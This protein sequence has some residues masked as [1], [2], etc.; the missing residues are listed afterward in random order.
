MF[1]AGDQPVE[2]SDA[3]AEERA[4]GLDEAPTG[5]LAA[6]ARVAADADAQTERETDK[7]T[8]RQV[9]AVRHTSFLTCA[10]IV[11]LSW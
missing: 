3:A 1:F 8:L 10:M 4:T 11:K 7:T 2:A 9:L 5:G 6:Q